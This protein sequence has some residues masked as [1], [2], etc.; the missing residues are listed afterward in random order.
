MFNPQVY[1]NS[2]TD[3]IGVLEVVSDDIK[4]PPQFVPLQR[5]EL[6]GA[7]VGPLGNFRLRQVFGYR[8]D[9]C[10]RVL[11]A[12]YRFP[13]PGDAAVTGVV[14]RFGDVEIVAELKARAAAEK[15]YTEAKKN[16]RQAA[17]ATRESPD[18]FTLQ[19]AGLQPD[20]E[21]VVETAFI[22][23]AR[24]EGAGWT[25]RIPLTTPPRYV[26][27]DEVN[28]RHAQ[29]QPLAL[30]R[31]PGHRFALD[32]TLQG[33]EQV[34][35]PTHA[36]TVTPDA[37]VNRDAEQ[38][39]AR[40]QAGAVIPDRDLVLTW[41]PMQA[42]TQPVLK[43][44]CHADQPT[45]RLYFLAQVAP[46]SLLQAGT[47]TPREVILLVDHSGSMTGPKWAAAD[48]AVERFLSDLSERDTFALGLFHNTTQWLAEEVQSATP[49][50]VVQAVQWLKQHTDSGGTELGVALE[51]ALAL[52]RPSGELARHVLIITDAA[53]SDAARILRLAD[54]EAAQTER[55][56]ISVLC[57]DAAPNAFLAQALAER[58][59]GMA[60]FLTS[61]PDQEDITTALDEVLAD[62]AEPVLAGLRLRINRALV[63]TNGRAQLAESE[64][65]KA[66]PTNSLID[67]GDL[68]SGRALWVV[69]RTAHAANPE[70]AFRLQTANGAGIAAVAVELAKAP[71][72]PA[73]K[74]LFGARRVNGLE[75]LINAGYSGEALADQLTRLG[76]DPEIVLAGQL[77]KP[78]KVY[79]ENAR[80]D[81]TAVL[82]ALLVQEALDYHLA[83]SETSFVAVRKEAGKPVTGTVVV[84]NALP[85]GWSSDF[86]THSGPMTAAR[87]LAPQS[88][89]MP[90][91]LPNVASNFLGSVRAKIA[92]SGIVGQTRSSISPS[93]MSVSAGQA[94]VFTGAPQFSG[95]EASLFD[96]SNATQNEQTIP[97][98]ITLTG[99]RGRL[100]HHTDPSRMLDRNLLILIFVGD[101]AAPR[102]K[103][104]LADLLRHA[105][106]PLNLFRP[107]S[108][109]VRIVLQDPNGSLAKNLPELELVLQWG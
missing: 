72:L 60:R 109:I 62:W 99:I 81:A 80:A 74:A 91:S 86:A 107:A 38:L 65:T 34:T 4:T 79:A 70:L 71:A 68:P 2:R 31:D 18:V 50:A 20:Q 39:R 14:V 28:S 75:Y 1:E 82:R 24:A 73:L 57:I 5:S 16:K 29:G 88:M 7:I 84:A 47:G 11:E 96:S 53:V 103:I 3:G 51:Q 19:I 102:A 94:V 61:E 54:Q 77:P 97:N 93:S 8:R 105:E 35:S 85:A 12:V 108:Q 9:V 43:V 55:R 58:G 76:Y 100:L 49:D 23:L 36:L 66:E 17:L 83:S 92:A 42:T 44:F 25:A 13:L 104:R 10:D 41:T 78:D 52:P 37:D 67:L 22:Q 46:P 40:L 101:L 32:I 95:T 69:G 6:T 87:S 63:E 45:D 15:A 33:V 98:E 90:A 89:P 56:L 27:S 64:S 21:V 59:G 30:L 48:W 106:R 26:R